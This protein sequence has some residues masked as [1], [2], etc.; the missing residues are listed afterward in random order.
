[1]FTLPEL[2]YSYDALE[3]YIDAV[4]MET[5]YSKHHQAYVS[6]LNAALEKYPELSTRTIEDL[7]IHLSNLPADVQTA[8]RNN[9]GGHY[10]HTFFWGLMNKD[11]AKEPTGELKNR[12]DVIW[13]DFESFKAK[14][15]A[16]ALSRFGSGWVWLVINPKGVLEITSTPNQDSPIT[17]GNHPILGLD[18]WEHAYYLKYTNKRADYVDQWWQV[19]NWSKVSELYKADK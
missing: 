8:V 6:N 1:M 9:G 19:V 16:A 3:P 2:N 14:F 5:H 12:I 18:V 11:G 17:E 4:T 13:G 10:N 7:L 15:K